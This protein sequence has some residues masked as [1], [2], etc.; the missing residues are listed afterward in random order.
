METW[1]AG[2]PLGGQRVA[3]Q[4]ERPS[5]VTRGLSVVAGVS[6][7][8]ELALSAVMLWEAAQPGSEDTGALGFAIILAC[9][10]GAVGLF[11]LVGGIVGW[12]LARRTAG[13]FA[14]LFGA[15][16]GGGLLLLVGMFVLS[17]LAAQP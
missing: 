12:L 16:A 4:Q 15:A 5:A 6:G 2:A 17:G 14:A 9:S 13:L 1:N 8:L 3:G 11:A 10:V 7:L